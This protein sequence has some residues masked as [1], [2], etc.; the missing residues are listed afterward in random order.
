M[1]SNVNNLGEFVQATTHL[2]SP[3]LQAVRLQLVQTGLCNDGSTYYFNEMLELFEETKACKRPAPAASLFPAGGSPSL[4]QPL[5]DY[6]QIIQVISLTAK[7]LLCVSNGGSRT[8]RTNMKTVLE[9][10][11]DSV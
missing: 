8:T 4:H 11:S 7:V 5:R 1:V 6:Y 3:L 9:E 2:I 10:A